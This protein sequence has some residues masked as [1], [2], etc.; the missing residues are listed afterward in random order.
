MRRLVIFYMLVIVNISC[1]RTKSNN[2]QVHLSIH[3]MSILAFLANVTQTGVNRAFVED[4]VNINCSRTVYVG[5][6]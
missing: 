6:T 3:S 4:L 5:S 1:E 2:A